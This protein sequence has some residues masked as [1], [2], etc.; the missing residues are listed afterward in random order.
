MTIPFEIHL[1][2]DGL[3]AEETNAFVQ[4][5]TLEGAKPLLMELS[6]GACIRQPM[7]TKVLYATSLDTV[8]TDT[9]MLCG[10]LLS[11][12]YTVNRVKIEIPADQAAT[13]QEPA[14]Y[15]EWHGKINYVQPAAL[16]QLCEKQEVHLSVNSLRNDPDTRFITLREY[17]PEPLFRERVS[18]LTEVLGSGGWELYKQQAEYCVYDTN[19]MLDKGWLT[20]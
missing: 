7:L 2:V 10:R 15:F 13:W 17:G 18:R 16:L 11:A 1:T 4:C 8:L 19:V 5:C 12:G 6:R 9:D 14:L 3:P 20:K